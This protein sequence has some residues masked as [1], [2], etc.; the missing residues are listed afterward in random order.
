[1][2][3]NLLGEKTLIADT[4]GCWAYNVRKKVFASGL[5]SGAV[6]ICKFMIE[7]RSES[8]V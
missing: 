8:D 3:S 7:D 1:M 2:Y 5:D 6:A 4:R